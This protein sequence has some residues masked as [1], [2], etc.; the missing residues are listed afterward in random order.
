MQN[1]KEMELWVH[2]A[3]EEQE[4]PPFQESIYTGH[5][6]SNAFLLKRLW[7]HLHSGSKVVKPLNYS[8]Y[9]NLGMPFS[10]IA[11]AVNQVWGT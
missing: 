2:T 5:L 9:L 7:V 3:A 1:P 10:P 11:G 4:S 6:D 8:L